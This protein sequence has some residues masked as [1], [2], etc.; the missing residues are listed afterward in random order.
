M[1]QHNA[2]TAGDWGGARALKSAVRVC[3][4]STVK[5]QPGASTT[6]ASARR[7]ASAASGAD[8]SRPSPKRTTGGSSR[9][10][11]SSAAR[12][13]WAGAR[14]CARV[15]PRWLATYLRDAAFR[16]VAGRLPSL[17]QTGGS[18]D[19]CRK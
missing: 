14:G 13:A 8:T 19:A 4:S 7:T 10:T 18:L 12:Q 16:A 2:S 15:V 1:R 9:R 3:T 6:S 11:G 17:P 5:V